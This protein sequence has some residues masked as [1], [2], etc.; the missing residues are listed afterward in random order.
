MQDRE[1]NIVRGYRNEI[2]KMILLSLL[3]KNGSYPYALL[4]AIQK[5]RMWFLRNVVKNDVYNA[6]SSMEKQGYIK[7]K[8]AFADSSARKNYKITPKGRRI[9]KAARITML[10]SFGD[11]AKMI[12][13]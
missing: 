4:K 6:L 7:S 11:I 1:S 9:I 13:E 3:I 8:M 12:K 2:L 10:N 5:K